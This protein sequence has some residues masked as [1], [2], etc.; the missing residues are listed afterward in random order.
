MFEYIQIALVI[1]LPIV[2]FQEMNELLLC[3]L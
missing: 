3:V 1:H 2:T